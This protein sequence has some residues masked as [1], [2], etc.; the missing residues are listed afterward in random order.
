MDAY[1]TGISLGFFLSFMIGP[2]FFV[3]IETS[4][5]KGFRAAISFDLG[6]VIADICFI[7]VAYFSSFRLIEKIKDEPALFLFGGSVMAVYGIISFVKLKKQSEVEVSLDKI[8]DKKKYLNL[9]AKGFL[10]NF[11]NIGV[12]GFWLA[13][14]ITIGPQLEM[15]PQK[16]L[17]FFASVVLSYVVT[18]VFKIV[19]AKQLR[20]KLT[21]TN[22]VRVKKVSSVL[23]IIFG[24]V[25]MTKAFIKSKIELP[26]PSLLNLEV[27][28]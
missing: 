15:D 23:L 12:L 1:L 26:E 21:T 7:A 22:I 8:D 3:L 2:V 6:V 10:L 24:F 9:F 18:D 11:I 14:L 20:S 28:K 17:F 13:I 25:I 27:K 4:L 5:T 16:L 19:L